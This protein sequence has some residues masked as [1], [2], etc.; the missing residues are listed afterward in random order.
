M[1]SSSACRMLTQARHEDDAVYLHCKPSVSTPVIHLQPGEAKCHGSDSSGYH[2]G[3]VVLTLRAGTGRSLT[4]RV[5]WSRYLAV[6]E[7]A[8][9]SIIVE[10]ILVIL[11]EVLELLKVELITHNGADTTE[12]LDELV[13]FRGAVRDKLER[14]TK[15]GVFLG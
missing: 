7:G 1:G 9:P 12:T 10:L 2:P 5:E 14:G 8:Q 4:R 13:A 3:R 6:S 15:V 11:I